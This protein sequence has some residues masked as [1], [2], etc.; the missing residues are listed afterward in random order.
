MSEI[1]E[2]S[3]L[4]GARQKYRRALT[5]REATRHRWGIKKKFAKGVNCF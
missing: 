1:R 4:V 5:V 3:S 2:M